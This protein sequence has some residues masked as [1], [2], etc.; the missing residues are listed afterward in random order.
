MYI[1]HVYGESVTEFS[2]GQRVALRPSCD[3]WMRGDRFGAVESV[4]RTR[5][6][7]RMDRS[8]KLRPIHPSNLAHMAAGAL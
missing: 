2:E 3:A 6:Y 5:V 8:Q 4:G 1:S 7:V